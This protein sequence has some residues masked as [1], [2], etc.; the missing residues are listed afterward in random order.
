MPSMLVKFYLFCEYYNLVDRW[1]FPLRL[2]ILN[3]VFSCLS[4]KNSACVFMAQFI[5]NV[6]TVKNKTKHTT[7]GS[8]VSVGNNVLIDLSTVLV[9]QKLLYIELELH[10]HTHKHACTHESQLHLFTLFIFVSLF[11]SGSVSKPIFSLLSVL[12]FYSKLLCCDSVPPQVAYSIK[13][14][15]STI[16]SA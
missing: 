4:L 5:Y 12:W 10:I 15:Y 16:G 9:N 2:C 7:L 6:I 8:N 11:T 1:Q 13:H 3:M 14:V